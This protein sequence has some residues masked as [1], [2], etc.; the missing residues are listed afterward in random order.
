MLKVGESMGKLEKNI[1]KITWPIFIEMLF[2]MLLGTVDTIMLSKYSDLAIGSVGVS[3]QLLFLFG[4][5]VNIVAIG[6][7]V[8]AAQYLGAKQIED[9]K[10]TVV[11]GIVTNTMIGLLLSLLILI[12]GNTLLRL[13]GTDD[14]LMKDS[15]TYLQIVGSSMVFVAIRVAIST[16]FRS[17]SRP[18]I[19]MYIM[20]LG[21]LV[22]IGVNAILIYGLFGAPS[23]GVQGAAIGTLV[24]RIIIVILLIIASYK[25]L[26]IRVFKVRLHIAHL[27]KILYIGI[28]SATENIL[29]S[30]SQVIIVYFLNKISVDAVIARSY[31]YTILSFIFIFSFSVANGN[32]IIV[33]YY[34]GEKNYNEAYKQTLKSLYLSFG[35]VVVMTI[36]INIFGY[37]I[38]GIFTEDTSLINLARS[39][40]YFAIFIEIGRAMN[41]VY[42]QALRTA[43]DTIF[44]VIMGAISMYGIA[45][46]FS[47]IFAIRLE[48]GIVGVFLASM[49]DEL[50]RGLS[51]AFRWYRK[52]WMEIKLI[53]S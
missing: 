16:G 10:D 17:F 53:K 11:T 42:I 28:P 4:V 34:L 18:R 22:N 3:N 24:S 51:M 49:M 38:I 33:G 31:I 37:E 29:W 13:I 36:L 9:A 5:V 27:R 26:S 15:L 44:P 7:G 32:S 8:V 25:V 50:F 41:M 23:L 2:F 14:I 21:N 52:N 40:L 1:F 30:L 39:V 48:M 43:G 20:I 19:V 47:Y 45:V 46:L 12:F 6:I 35:L